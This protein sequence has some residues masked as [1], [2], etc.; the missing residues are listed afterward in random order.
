MLFR[1]QVSVP[2][3]LLALEPGDVI[4]LDGLN[5]RIDRIEE[6]GA[7]KLDAIRVE[8]G[9]YTSAYHPDRLFDAPGLVGAGP[10]LSEVLDLPLLRGDE[11][12]HAPYAAAA[13]TPWPG[14]VNVFLSPS[15]SGYELAG[16]IVRHAPDGRV[17]HVEHLPVAQ[18][19]CPALTP[20]G[21]LY[22][23]TAYEGM[24]AAARAADPLSGAVFH[25]CDGVPGCGE[26]RVIL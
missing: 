26:P 6:R 17:D 20:E 4:E 3:S 15:E 21:A 9:V 18:V 2:P 22:A 10:V 25:V 14:P 11:V 23:T 7:R 19:T 1:S 16:Q 5:W 13:A 8:P 12:E 24:D